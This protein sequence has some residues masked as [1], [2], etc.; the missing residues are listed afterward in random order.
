MSQEYIGAVVL[1]LVGIAQAFG[2]VVEQE[3]I[4]GIVTGVVA[5]WVAIRRYKKG[6][7]SVGGVRKPATLNN[8]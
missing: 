5:L 4:M 8:N 2:I 1:I 6:D 7:I 3:A